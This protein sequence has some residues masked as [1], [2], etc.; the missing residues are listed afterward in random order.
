[1]RA[2]L[3]LTPK[4][5]YTTKVLTERL[6]Y[7]NPL[8]LTNLL[9]TNTTL[10][11]SLSFLFFFRRRSDAHVSRPAYLLQSTPSNAQGTTIHAS[12]YNM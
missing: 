3:A 12:S 11:S 8:T 9:L 2:I 10:S 1:M 7:G 5:R 6:A 4:T